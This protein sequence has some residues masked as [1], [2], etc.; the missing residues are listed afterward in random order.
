MDSVLQ[1]LVRKKRRRN[2]DAVAEELG[3]NRTAF[4]CCM[5]YFQKFTNVSDNR[6]WTNAEDEKLKN[7]VRICRIQN[8]VPWKKVEERP[9]SPLCNDE[10][11]LAIFASG[12]LLHARTNE[13]PVLSTLH[14]VPAGYDKERDFY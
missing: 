1:D 5:R 11:D 7:L 6:K 3:T 9:P 12:I 4:L 13:R 2:W 14:V 10:M 8:C